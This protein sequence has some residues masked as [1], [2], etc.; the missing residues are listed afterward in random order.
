MDKLNPSSLDRARESDK[1]HAA[2]FGSL[3]YQRLTDTIAHIPKGSIFLPDG[4]VVPGYPAIARIHRLNPGIPKQFDGPFWA[5]EKMDGF[6]ARIFRHGEQCYAA[7]RGGFI[8][9]F[10]TDRLADRFDG[11]ILNNHPDLVICAEYVGPDNPYLEGHSPQVQDDV[12]IFVFDIMHKNE[13]GFLPQDERM[14]LLEEYDLQSAEIFGRFQPDDIEVLRERM[15]RLDEEGKEGLVLKPEDDGQRAKY[16][17]ARSNSYDFSVT[18]EALM[19]LPPEYFTNRLMR[20]SLFLEEHGLEQDPDRLN[21]LG[22]AMVQGLF[23]SIHLSKDAGRIGH[24][25]RIRFNEKENAKRFI[26]HIETT[27]GRRVKVMEDMPEREGDHWILEFERIH[28]RMTGT[29]NQALQGG[30]QF[31]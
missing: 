14:T 9:P 7:T 26:D 28:Q 17:T 20:M 10:A 15:L 1:L 6:N 19:D 12:D 11:R 13:A 8:C 25:Y 16:V 5:E 22:H 2:Q 23:R 3:H 18:G 29:L 27:G 31:D 30:R 21:E 4:D 24:R